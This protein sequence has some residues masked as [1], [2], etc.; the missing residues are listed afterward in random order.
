MKAKVTMYIDK[1]VW[2]NF[3]VYAESAGLSASQ[4]TEFY[5][6]TILE[7]E[8]KPLA[9][10]MGDAFKEGFDMALKNKRKRK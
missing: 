5:M 6:R 9:K 3:K 4:V 8:K 1:E 2:D 7:S 10:L